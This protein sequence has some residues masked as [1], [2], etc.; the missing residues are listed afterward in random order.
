VQIEGC[1]L[2]RADSPLQSNDEVDR[3]GIRIV[4]AVGSAY[5]LYLQRNLKQATLVEVAKSEGVA[6]AMLAEGADVGAGVR[7]QVEADAARLGGLRLL[8]GRFMAIHQA[9]A[10]PRG[11]AEA[12]KTWLDGFVERMKR[13]GFAAEALRRHGIDGAQVAPPAGA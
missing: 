12:A 1:Y 5:G 6:Q 7:Q 4:A 10:L 9:M 11:R 3:A 2:V 13:T 8:P